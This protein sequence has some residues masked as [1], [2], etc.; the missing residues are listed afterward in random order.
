LPA[1]VLHEIHMATKGPTNPAKCL[2]A[3][4]A[5]NRQFIGIESIGPTKRKTRKVRTLFQ[6][7]I[8][9]KL[10]ADLGNPAVSC[11]QR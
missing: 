3:I 2:Q 6:P 9:T 8:A 7:S 10:F 1:A 5:M 4:L 11:F